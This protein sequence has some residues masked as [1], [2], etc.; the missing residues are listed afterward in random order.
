MPVPL[1]DWETE[2]L[3][4]IKENRPKIAADW[5]RW[6]KST[7]TDKS[8]VIR[9]ARQAYTQHIRRL[10]PA[11]REAHAESQRV[12]YEDPAVKEVH[13][14]R[15][16]KGEIIGGVKGKG[17]LT[18]RIIPIL[19]ESGSEAQ[20]RTAQNLVEKLSVRGYQLTQADID[21]YHKL[22]D[23]AET[24]KISTTDKRFRPPY[25][26]TQV[27]LQSLYKEVWE[28][29][30]NKRIFNQRLQQL[31]DSGVIDE[32]QLKKYQLSPGHG[33]SYKGFPEF[34]ADL[35]NIHAETLRHNKVAGVKL[36]GAQ[37][38]DQMKSILT[39]RGLGI[40]AT[41]RSKINQFGQLAEKNR[42]N[43]DFI[44]TS[45]KS[46]KKTPSNMD[47]LLKY[48]TGYGVE[49]EYGLAGKRTIDPLFKREA[50][51]LEGQRS[52]A[53]K[54]IEGV[55]GGIMTWGKRALSKAPIVGSLLVPS[56]AKAYWDEGQKGRAISSLLGV[57]GIVPEFLFDW[58]KMGH[59]FQGTQA[60]IDERR[61]KLKSTW[62]G[63]NNIWNQ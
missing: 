5:K 53:S 42:F 14:M 13:A 50:L 35:N 29:E 32:Q 12:R 7:T 27:E 20:V 37:V 41:T 63:G 18:G 61:K 30:Q 47:D 28:Y 39:D 26:K 60:E 36:T 54:A 8:I 19:Q 33:F 17:G 4:W 52:A 55:K 25:G 11:Y 10:N 44:Y 3:P 38:V 49:G 57:S 15:T 43:P 48:F 21:T 46:G 22:K 62:R 40:D 23:S 9:A 1:H 51:S 58:E 34:S 56:I 59:R 24:L 6:G 31:V 16:R 2:V 45:S